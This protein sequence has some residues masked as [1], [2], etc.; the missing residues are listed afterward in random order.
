MGTAYPGPKIHYPS[1]RKLGRG[2]FPAAV[3][4]S[5]TITASGSTA[6]LE[7]A[8]PVTVTGLVPVTV[9]GATAVSQVVV[10]P[11]VVTILY[12]APLAGLAYSLA[13]NPPTA[14][15]AQGGAVY[16]TS[17]T[18]SGPSGPAASITVV[19]TVS[20]GLYYVTYSEP[21]TVIS[22]ATPEPALQLLSISLG[23]Q[24]ATVQILA[25]ADTLEVV[26][27][28]GATDIVAAQMAGQPTVFATV[29]GDP[30]TAGPTIAIGNT[31][32]SLQ[33]PGEIISLN[34]I[35]SGQ[36]WITTNEPLTT[37]GTPGN[38][39]ASLLFFGSVSGL[40][41]PLQFSA[42]VST[43]VVE[44]QDP[45]QIETYTEAVLVLQPTT[46]SLLS[47]DLFRLGNPVT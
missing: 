46:F 34:A 44:F 31:D 8:R 43:Y 13:A 36:Y 11:T 39:D 27:P 22:P 24:T 14:M 47:G 3:G 29:S 16:G 2:Q 18:F 12:T 45:V 21:V 28:T 23:W 20:P 38:P 25:G 9:I 33:P 32:A 4:T 37:T 10:S 41:T 15:T 42:Y 30:F 26:S 40:W 17:G 5:V 6:T 7:F 1:R 19:A 35:G